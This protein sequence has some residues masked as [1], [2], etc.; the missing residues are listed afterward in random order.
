MSPVGAQPVVCIIDSGIRLSHEDFAGQTINGTNDPGT[1]NWFN[2]DCGH[3][4][5]VAGTIAAATGNGLGVTS[6]AGSS[7]VWWSL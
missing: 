4:T 5:H 1:G 7:G 6:V 2:D 3:G